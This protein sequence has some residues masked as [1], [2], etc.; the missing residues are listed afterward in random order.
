MNR[1]DGLTHAAEPTL[2]A[3]QCCAAQVRV[4]S[5]MAPPPSAGEE[6]RPRPGGGVRIDVHPFIVDI[7]C[8]QAKLVVEV[9]GEFHGDR[10]IEDRDRTLWLDA[11]GYRVVR[12]AAVDVLVELEA[13]VERLSLLLTPSPGRGRP[14]SPATGGSTDDPSAALAPNSGR[15]PHDAAKRSPG[16]STIRPSP[17]RNAF[18]GQVSGSRATPRRR[19]AGSGSSSPV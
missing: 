14:T 19:C 13:V 6:G 15:T 10:M 5:S 2:T 7:S 8:P 3:T 12:F 1:E 11:Q 4:G 16:R 9:D 18:A 17:V